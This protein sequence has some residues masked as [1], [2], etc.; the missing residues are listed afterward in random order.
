MP[1]ISR[2]AVPLLVIVTVSGELVEPTSMEPKSIEVGETVISGCGVVPASDTEASGSSGSLE[3]M[4]KLADL[5][6]KE[7]GLKVTVTLAEAL[8]GRVIDEAL[9]L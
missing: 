5:E 3:G 8:G 9:S 1:P 7:V 2:S 4:D 6:P